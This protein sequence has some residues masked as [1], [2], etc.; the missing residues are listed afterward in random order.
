ML[1]R[2]CTKCQTEYPLTRQFFKNNGSG[3]F[4]YQC[5]ECYAAWRKTHRENPT[6][7][8]KDRAYSRDN[9]QRLRLEKY[10]IEKAEYDDLYAKQKG[11]CAICREPLKKKHCID[12]D[13]TTGKVRGLLCYNCNITIGRFNDDAERMMRAAGYVRMEPLE[14]K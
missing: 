12:H 9:A 13:H 14:F 11:A 3:R 10:A 2:A 7:R 1:M 5:R 6:I 8:A 4:K